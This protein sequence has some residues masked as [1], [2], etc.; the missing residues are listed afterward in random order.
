VAWNLKP[1]AL[2]HR[3][4]VESGRSTAAALWRRAVEERT[5]E[6]ADNH[7]KGLE[8]LAQRY[9]MRL[10]TVSQRLAERFVRPLTIDLLRSLVGP[11]MGSDPDTD[12]SDAFG[13]LEIEVEV[14][15]AEAGGAG[16]DLPDW[17]EA[18][19]E[20]AEEQQRLVRRGDD[21]VDDPLRRIDQVRLSWEETQEQL[22]SDEE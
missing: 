9:G 8:Q 21:Q 17:V 22:G 19:E 5:R 3:I 15:L 4:L 7:Q 20:E 10:P 16:L 18:L 12:P 13:A 11:A 6:A 2:A 14:L 1:V